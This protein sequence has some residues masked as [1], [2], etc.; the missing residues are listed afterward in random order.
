MGDECAAVGLRA[1]KGRRGGGVVVCFV[2]HGFS[3]S[4]VMLWGKNLCKCT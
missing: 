3:Q 4:H 1:G 2:E